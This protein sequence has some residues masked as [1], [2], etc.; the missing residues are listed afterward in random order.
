MKPEIVLTR[1]IYGPAMTALDHEYTLHKLWTAPDRQAYLKE[2]GARIRGVVTTTTVGLSTAE[3]DAM[4]NLEI[5]ASFSR[6]L[7]AMDLAVAKQRGIIVTNVPLPISPEVGELAVGLLLSIARRIVEA[8]RYVRAGK[9][10]AAPFQMGRAL[11]DMRCGVVGLGEVGMNFAKRAEPFVKSLAYF[12]IAPKPGVS[13]QYYSDLEAMARDS[14]CLVVTITSNAAT[15]N[16]VNARILD[17]LG[18]DGFLVNVSRGAVVDQDALIAALREKRIAGAGLDVFAD[19]PRVPA[20]L[21]Q[22][23]NVVMTPHIGSSTREVREERMRNVLAN[24]RA[25]FSMQPVLTRLA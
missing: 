22:L 8:D 24:L 2:H 23:D 19:E 16:I 17:A 21:R 18:T 3:M 20:E 14:D 13:Y 12:D 6:S 25:H 5:V 9:W 10:E 15:R 7:G 4:P 11:R 1:A